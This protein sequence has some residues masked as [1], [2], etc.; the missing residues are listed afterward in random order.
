MRPLMNVEFLCG[1]HRIPINYPY[2][3][4]YYYPPKRGNK[5]KYVGVCDKM[6][7]IG[8]FDTE[9]DLQDPFFEA[10]LECNN[11]QLSIYLFDYKKGKYVK[12]KR[13][14]NWG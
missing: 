4:Q 11:N 12:V 10:V 7:I 9:T 8:K 2:F 13:Y 14:L 6:A 1:N 3:V 5:Y